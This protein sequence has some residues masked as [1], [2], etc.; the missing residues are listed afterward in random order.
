MG[1]LNP[2][3]L[4]WCSCLLTRR[5]DSSKGSVLSSLHVLKMLE[6][7]QSLNGQKDIAGRIIKVTGVLLY[8]TR[9]P[10]MKIT[11]QV[12]HY[13]VGISSK[14]SSEFIILLFNQ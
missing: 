2:V 7:L 6:L 5:M 3:L 9:R 11:S 8:K 13:E 4:S 1:C 10:H 12:H 14:S